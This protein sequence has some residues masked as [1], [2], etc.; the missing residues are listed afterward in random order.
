MRRIVAIGFAAFTLLGATI[1]PG[2]ADE[3][4]KACGGIRGL[5]CDAGRFCEF[6]AETQRI[7]PKIRIDFRKARCAA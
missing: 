2:L 7:G 4:V 5:T 6:P 3:P 1:L